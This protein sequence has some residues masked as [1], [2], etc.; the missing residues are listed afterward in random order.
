[1]ADFMADF[2]AGTNRIVMRAWQTY[3]R[4]RKFYTFFRVQFCAY[5]L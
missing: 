3:A 5:D 4:N 2:M 1:M